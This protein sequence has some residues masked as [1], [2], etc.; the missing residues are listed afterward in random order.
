MKH[1]YK[2]I[3]FALVSTLALSSCSKTEGKG[4]TSSIQGEVNGITLIGNSG[5]IAEKEITTVICTHADGVGGSIL[6]NSDYFLLN[7]PNGGPLYYVWYENTNWLGQDPGLS[8]RTGI[9]VT[10]SNS[11]SNVTIANNTM[12]AINTIASADFT[13]TIN[14][15]IVTIENNSTGEVV[16]AD[17]VN[18][19]FVIDTQNQ[20]KGATSGSGSQV[21]GPIIDERVYIIYGEEDF[22]SE[23]VRTD[24]NGKYQF[25]GL[26]KGD[27]RVFSFSLDTVSAGGLLHQIEVAASIDKN[28][29]VTE[30]P[31]I[32]IVK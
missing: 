32:S 2:A 15:D 23:S 29:T 25:T 7:T 26:T 16:D 3:A 28:K 9:K 8:G 22:Y 14:S 5:N 4:G 6:D 21:S 20:G 31:V 24:E 17:D 10:Y 27:Y 30:A 12:T 11:Q 18:T 1:T 13:A 19:P